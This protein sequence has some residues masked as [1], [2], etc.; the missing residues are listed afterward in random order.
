M[1]KKNNMLPHLAQFVLDNGL[2][3]SSLR[4]MAKAAGTSDRMLIYHFGSKIG[5][6]R[7]TL[8]FIASQLTVTLDGLFANRIFASE[9]ELIRSVTDLFRAET[10]RPFVLLWLDIVSEA[11][12]GSDLHRDVG[13]RI[14]DSYIEWIGKYHPQGPKKAAETLIKI[15]GSMI[16]DA[17]GRH[18]LTDGFL[19]N[20]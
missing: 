8:D 14:I 19:K 3:A 10:F 4:P 12:R 7:E 17:V 2:T 13:S 20:L 18:D 1:S 16:I 11:A 15:D 6:L 5:V 9:A